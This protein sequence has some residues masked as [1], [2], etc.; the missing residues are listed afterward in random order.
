MIDDYLMELNNCN[1]FIPVPL[2]SSLFKKNPWE[3]SKVQI[4]S[5]KKIVQTSGL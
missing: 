5:K 3:K 4:T 1:F 2:Y